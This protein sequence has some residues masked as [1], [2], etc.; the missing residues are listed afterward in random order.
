[1]DIFFDF[2]VIKF[3]LTIKLFKQIQNNKRNYFMKK[4][5][6]LF[7]AFF[8]LFN[9]T[10]WAKKKSQQNNEPLLIRG[11]VQDIQHHP[12]E[13]VTVLIKSRAQQS[14]TNSQGQ[15]V[16]KVPQ[17][18]GT[19]TLIFS[20]AHFHPYSLHF[21]LD[22]LKKKLSVVLIPKEY[23][24]E[25]VSITALN[26]EEKSVDVPSAESSVSELEIKE[27]IPENIVTTML[28]TPG[29]HFIGSGGFSITPS[30]RGLA[31]RRVLILVDGMRVTG[32]RRAGVSAT[33]L[34]PELVNR[35][36]MVRSSSSV[37][38]GSDALGG[39]IHIITQT[40]Q[41]SKSLRNSL[42]LSLSSN[43]KRINSGFMLQQ[44]ISKINLSAAFQLTSANNYST[45]SEEIFH[46]GFTYYSGM[47]NLQS[48]NE[49]RE[50]SLSYMGGQG[51]GIGKPTRDNDPVSYTQV[52]DEGEHYFRFHYEEKQLL[53]NGKIELL[54]YLN[55]SL[56]ALEKYKAGS[57]SKE[58]SHTQGHNLG[59]KLTLKKSLNK[60]FSIQ[61]GLEWFGRRGFEFENKLEEPD[62]LES[63]YPLLNG[64]RDDYSL[65]FTADY[66]G[67][68][69][70]DLL[71]G[72]RY[73]WFS[74]QALVEDEKREKLS[75]A[76]SY[77]L[78]LT[79]KFGKS[80]N[81]FV[82]LGRAFRLPGLSESFYT[83]LTGRKYVI[84]NPDLI[85]ESSF[86]L[87]S[88]IKI[89]SKKFFMGAYI[90]SYHI[91]DMIERYKNQEGIYTYDN[92][93]AGKIYGGELEFQFFPI[94][95]LEIFGHYFYYRGRSS[96]QEDPLNDIPSPKML[97]G[98]KLLI[99][100]FWTEINYLHSY[101]KT[102]PGPAEVENNGYS[103]VN[104]KAGYYFSTHFY[105]NFKIANFFNE[106]YYPNADP[107]IPPARGID[108]SL[109][110]H[111]YF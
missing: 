46:S 56:Y 26:R 42:N 19:I 4:P 48:G 17:E 62:K 70:L 91:K 39:V 105:L 23:I 79:K 85:P 1:M 38:Y 16:L 106:L 81:L 86:N 93:D 21:N 14:F 25:E 29:I 55:P 69:S 94:N 50:F 100:R 37:L 75:D 13:G 102:D 57:L 28:N 78:G 40:P 20:H 59:G 109:G 108:I 43:N 63:T 45:P 76:P 72:I 101:Q 84:G 31:R 11:V 96:S 18:P 68:P 82:N 98:G 9:Y 12:I 87:D 2:F 53:K 52:S 104:I 88:G 97:L 60:N 73:T 27:K 71:G 10:V 5:F 66:K 90:F 22:N 35:I 110:L 24:Q 3:K 36:E 80:I 95:N 67:I 92:I 7:L 33:F 64:E 49:N 65:F 61:T 30:I 77:F 34:A 44:K 47:F 83:G 107:D 74:L 6:L 15:F 99:D 8:L 103:E 54:L 89:F 32:D 51:T 41:I 58:Y 111:Y